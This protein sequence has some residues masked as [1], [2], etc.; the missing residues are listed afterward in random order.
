MKKWLIILI[1]V[2]VATIGFHIHRRGAATFFYV[3]E[4]IEMSSPWRF[5]EERYELFDKGFRVEKGN[6][7]W[8]AEEIFSGGG[9]AHK[10]RIMGLPV[11]FRRVDFARNYCWGF[12]GIPGVEWFKGWPQKGRERFSECRPVV[13]RYQ[14]TKLNIKQ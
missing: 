9:Y 4:K 2:L 10:L 5:N 12:P 11:K 8:Y 13:E 14:K 6:P 3:S 1:V 7:L